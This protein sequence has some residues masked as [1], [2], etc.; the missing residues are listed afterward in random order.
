MRISIGIVSHELTGFESGFD[1]KIF[2]EQVRLKDP[3]VESRFPP[4]S[5]LQFLRQKEYSHIRTSLIWCLICSDLQAVSKCER[6]QRIFF[7]KG[8]KTQPVLIMSLNV[9]GPS[10][11]FGAYSCKGDM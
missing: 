9:L 8:H 5:P 4:P 2:K 1:A 10:Q 6:L 11:L 7:L 3:G